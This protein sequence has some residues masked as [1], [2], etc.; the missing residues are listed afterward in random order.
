MDSVWSFL[1]QR[2]TGPIY[3]YTDGA[4]LLGILGNGEIWASDALH[5]NDA[6]E[7]KLSMALLHAELK[8]RSTELSSEWN[9]VLAESK[10]DPHGWT[11]SRM[12]VTSFSTNGNQLSQWR[13]YCRDGSGFSIGFYPSDLAYAQ[14][15]GSFH[16]VKCVYQPDEQVGLI[17]AVVSYVQKGWL[18]AR[19]FKGLDGLAFLFR[20]SFKAMAVMLAIKDAGFEEEQEWRLVGEAPDRI[21]PRFR[22]GRYGIVSYC[23]LPLCGPNDQPTI[24]NIY[25]S[26]ND[27]VEEAMISVRDFLQHTT[28]YPY[29]KCTDKVLRSGIPYRY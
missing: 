12:Y 23:A 22:T 18:K 25:V 10:A 15:T 8:K 4:G 3:H 26:P 29:S 1:R 2:P 27:N 28:T 11:D 7:F 5:L 21:P 13:S 20:V 16:L 14:R 24:A 9:S 19:R 6:K 17:R